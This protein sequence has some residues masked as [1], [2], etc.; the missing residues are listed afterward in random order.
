MNKLNIKGI[1]N[2]DGM[3]FHD[4]E[5]GF[6]EEKKAMLAKEVAHIHG[7]DLKEINRIINF[8]KKRFIDGIDILDLKNTKFE[9]FLNHHEIYSQNALNR[10]SN[11]YILSERGYSKL[12]KILEDDFAW[13]QYEK[14]VYGYF[15]MRNVATNTY[16]LSKEIQAIFMLDEKT[17]KQDE[18]ISKL[19]N[20]MTINYGQQQ[21]LH[22]LANRSVIKVLGGKDTPAYKELSKKAFAT[23]WRDFKRVMNVS[24]YR[25]TAV[26]EFERAIA[27]LKEWKPNREL[28]LM[29]KGANSQLILDVE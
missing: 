28:H 19:E 15:N 12:L 14:L 8:N 25:N 26:K 21:E 22:T 13:E 10:S 24:S 1:I 4:I 27:F 29:I 20:T 17:Q 2:V 9:V 7:R 11:I 6:G 3:K 16:K 23:I 18:R 5:G